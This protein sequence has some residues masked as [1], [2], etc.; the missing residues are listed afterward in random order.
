MKKNKTLYF[1]AIFIKKVLPNNV[2][3]ENTRV[4]EQYITDNIDGNNFQTNKLKKYLKNTCKLSR[5]VI[6][7]LFKTIQ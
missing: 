4:L 6:Q 3:V 7:K 2:V 5:D 1:L